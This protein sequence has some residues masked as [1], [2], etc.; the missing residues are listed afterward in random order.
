MWKAGGG[1]W[2]MFMRMKK[3]KHHSVA[4]VLKQVNISL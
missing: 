4:F 2:E 3:G 1:E